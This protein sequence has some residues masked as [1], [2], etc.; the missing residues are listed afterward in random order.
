M[1]ASVLCGMAAC[2]AAH[3]VSAGTYQVIQSSLNVTR[4]TSVT[5]F[6]SERAG[7]VGQIVEMDG[8]VSGLIAN[9]SGSAFLLRTA[10]GQILMFAL[11]Q[12]D[13]DIDVSIS[14]RVLARVPPGN[15]MLEC[16]AA[17]PIGPDLAV[18][19]VAVAP[20]PEVEDNSEL[21]IVDHLD[22][23]NTTGSGMRVANRPP[24]IYHKAPDRPND[25]VSLQ[26]PDMRASREMVRQY[27]ER[28]QACNGRIGSDLAD[29]IAY[30][31]LD[32]CQQYNVDPRLMF[33]LVAQESRFN[34]TAVSR[35]GA[36]GLGQLMPGTAAGLG[37]RDAFDIADNLDG[38]VRYLANQ[39]RN[40]GKLSLALAAYN[41]GPGNVKRY[42]GV[43]PFR[44]TRDYIRKIWNHYCTLVGLNP[45]TGEP[46]Q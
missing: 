3:A 8:V 42:G 45:Q 2:T 41:A 39:L 9:N 27:S 1:L 20:L 33:A 25:R 7:K 26:M 6:L 40:H 36:Q 11:R 22:R 37:V 12:D 38:A 46:A 21:G 35:S 30:H 34:P 4:I 14:L 13:P 17:T 28:I 43:P 5:K 18:S 32:R 29:R 16:L 19:P 15:S 31:L 44:E 23:V 24:V 10:D